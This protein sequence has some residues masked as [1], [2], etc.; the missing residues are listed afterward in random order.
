[1]QLKLSKARW[2]EAALLAPTTF[3]LG[4]ALP[5]GIILTTVTLGASLAVGLAQGRTG[6][7]AA[8]NSSREV[9]GL[10]LMMLAGA[11][12]LATLWLVVLLGREWLYARPDWKNAAVVALAAGLA[13]AAYWFTRLEIPPRDAGARKALLVWTGLLL[14]PC[15]LAVRYLCVLLR[16]APPFTQHSPQ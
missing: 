16:R 5:F 4:S 1:M 14:F 3:V 6:F 10:W 12:G 13:S 2:I 11:A 9:G 8:L 7:I 15:L